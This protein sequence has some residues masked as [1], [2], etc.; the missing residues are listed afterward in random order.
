MFSGIKI[1][2]RVAQTGSP[3]MSSAENILCI[4]KASHISILRLLEVIGKSRNEYE[5]LIG[6]YDISQIVDILL[7]KFHAPIKECIMNNA[8][9]F[10]TGDVRYISS[11]S[12]GLKTTS[13]HLQADQLSSFSIP[14]LCDKFE[15][16]TP[17]LWEL[18]M[19]LV[20][21]NPAKKDISPSRVPGLHGPLQEQTARERLHPIVS[22]V[23][24]FYSNCISTHV[25]V[26]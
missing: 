2:E 16:E 19:R 4:M 21:I 12:F 15:S 18:F 25:E 8:V 1:N 3:L 6:P 23:H 26:L 13:Y 10:Y 24:V 17:H 22:G 5:A 11:S 14:Y 20:N 7:E 9:T